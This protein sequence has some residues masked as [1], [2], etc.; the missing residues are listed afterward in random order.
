MGTLKEIDGKHY[1]QCKVVMMSA[2]QSTTRII[3]AE[4]QL[5]LLS[6][7]NIDKTREDK[8]RH[9]YI[10]SDEEIKEGD[11]VLSGTNTIV[12]CLHPNNV[13]DRDIKKIIATTDT[14]LK[15]YTSETLASASGFS[16]KTEDISLSKPSQSFIKAYIEAY[17]NGNPITD[18]LVEHE[19]ELEA[20]YRNGIGGAKLK[21]NS[22]NEITIKKV[23]DS[24]TREEVIELVTKALYAKASWYEE[25]I[26]DWIKEN[27]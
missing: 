16:L 17:N 4:K 5:L 27:L 3:L 21:V 15:L 14:S 10:T 8:G 1:Q 9:L 12:Q 6:F 11:W 18:V 22:S 19:S 13:V 2:G 20:Y 24:Y 23:K 7:L 25:E 26:N